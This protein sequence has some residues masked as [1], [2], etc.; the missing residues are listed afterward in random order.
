MLAHSFSRH[1]FWERTHF[2]L[3]G[4]ADGSRQRTSTTTRVSIYVIYSVITATDE[5]SGEEKR[6]QPQPG[7]NRTENESAQLP[8]H[9]FPL[10]SH[11]CYHREAKM[12]DYIRL[13][14][15]GS[16]KC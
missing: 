14:S 1:L 16:E 3:G 7:M 2:R 5:M 12:V 15:K 11:T 9:L 13:Q 10:I 8:L 6:Q 4:C